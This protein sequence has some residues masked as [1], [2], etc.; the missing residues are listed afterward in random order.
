M[1]ATAIQIGHD[2]D[3]SAK[4][5]KNQSQNDAVKIFCFDL[6]GYTKLTQFL[7]CCIGVVGSIFLFDLLN[8]SCWYFFLVCSIFGLWIPAG[9]DFYVGW[10]QAI[11]MVLD[12]YSILLLHNFWLCGEAHKSGSTKDTYESILYSGWTHVGHHGF[13]KFKLRI[14]ELPYRS[15]FCEKLNTENLIKNFF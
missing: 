5:S 11:R 4:E 9:V 10:I 6:S 15:K 2:K 8:F 7:L 13:F 3:P 1:S 14:F 12:T